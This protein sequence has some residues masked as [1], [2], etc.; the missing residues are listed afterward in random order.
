M[1]SIDRTH[2]NM[3]GHRNTGNGAAAHGGGNAA[4]PVIQRPKRTA[5]A[6]GTPVAGR[7]ISV[8]RGQSGARAGAPHPQPFP[9]KLR[10]G[11]EPVRRT[12]P[13]GAQSNSP[14]PHGVYGGEAG[15]GGRPRHAPNL[16]KRSPL[17]GW[18]MHGNRRQGKSRGLGT[19][20]AAAP[21]L[22]RAPC[23]I[24]RP[25]RDGVWASA[26]R[27]GLWM[28]D[29]G[30]RGV[31]DTKTARRPDRSSPPLPL[32]GEGAGGRG[33]AGECAAVSRNAPDAASL[34]HT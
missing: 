30:A 3:P 1:G 5:L 33:Q 11:R 23:K 32:A 28:T 4:G 10:G 17:P 27:L 6:R 25:A 24:L 29:P 19:V 16:S 31:W 15:R 8:L 34:L 2:G 21:G 12:R 14:L 9:R 7:R 20:T 22:L 13:A 26:V 18:S